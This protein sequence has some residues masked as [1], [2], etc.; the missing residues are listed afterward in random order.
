[1]HLTLLNRTHEVCCLEYN[2]TLHI[3]S[4]ILQI[5]DAKRAPIGV[6]SDEGDALTKLNSWW[7]SRRIPFTRGLSD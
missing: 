4:E 7:G 6:F 5:H 1:M 3:F 2:E